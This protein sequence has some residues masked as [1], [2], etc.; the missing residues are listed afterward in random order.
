[1]KKYTIIYDESI[2]KD[3]H[4]RP[5]T[6]YMYTNYRYIEC[7]PKDLRETVENEVGRQYGLYLGDI[8]K[9]QTHNIKF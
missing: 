4:C 5:K 6:Y 3:S 2:E 8:A 1:M 7:H 9:M